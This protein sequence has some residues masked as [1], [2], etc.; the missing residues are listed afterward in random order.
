MSEWREIKV[1]DIGDF[2]NVDVIELMVGVGDRI[3]AESP[4]MTL[5]TDKAAMEIPAEEAGVIREVKVAVG[6]TVSQGDIVF[7]FEA[8]TGKGSETSAPALLEENPERV[9]ESV[10]PPG[11]KTGL[12]EPV[13]EVAPVQADP[14]PAKKV[15]SPSLQTSPSSP[16]RLPFASPA[17]R[18]YAREL[19]V[20]L[21]EVTGSGKG[22][23]IL[24]SDVQTHVKARLKK[25]PGEALRP[26]LLPWPK[27]DFS[28]FGAISHEPLSRMKKLSGA[29]LHRNWSLIPHVTQHDEVDISEMEDFRK[30]QADEAAERGIKLTPLIFLIKACVSALKKYPQFNASLS[31]EGETLILKQYYHIGI[32]VD[33]PDG[34]VVPVLRDCDRLSLFDLAW[35]LMDLSTR[36]RKRKL[37]VH[38]LEGGCFSISSLGGIGG[39][40]FTPIIN[41]PEVAIL[42]VSKAVQKAV[43]HEGIFVPRL[44]LPLS[45][46]YDHRVI[47]GAAAVRFTRYLSEVLSDIRRL[48]L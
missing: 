25:V 36:A 28:R 26:G 15:P 31:E 29:N 27:I 22:G 3:A 2:K 23:R 39:T 20:D 24:N 42:G 38:E 14:V 4:L 45:L 33:T 32:A 11:A 6:D 18:R 35:A 16:D 9:S 21:N 48:L 40:G 30:K 1:P 8:E 43:Y 47:D 7:L 37:T 5:E 13:L 44:M 34:L 17:V 46:S 10:S 19:G 41:A 12:P